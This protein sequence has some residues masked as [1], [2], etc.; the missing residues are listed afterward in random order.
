M[1]VQVGRDEFQVPRRSSSQPAPLSQFTSSHKRHGKLGKLLTSSLLQ[2]RL[3]LPFTQLQSLM[4]QDKGCIVQC[5]RTV[6]CGDTKKSNGCL[7]SLNALPAMAPERPL[8]QPSLPPALTH[9]C[10]HLPGWFWHL[11][12][13]GRSY[14]WCH[15]Q[16]MF[17]QSEKSVLV[18]SACCLMM[19]E[20]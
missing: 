14:C 20:P 19:R 8:G 3:A 16:E 9:A 2:L 11:W 7:T 12:K 13:L 15:Q 17:G 6:C 18:A 4:I 1:E 10:A 5:R